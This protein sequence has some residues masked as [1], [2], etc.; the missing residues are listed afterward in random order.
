MVHRFCF[1]ALSQVNLI[2][3]FLGETNPLIFWREA[4]LIPAQSQKQILQNKNH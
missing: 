3:F 1:T 4:V 2:N